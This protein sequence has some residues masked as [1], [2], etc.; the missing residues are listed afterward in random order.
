MQ[1]QFVKEYVL[2][3]SK[4]RSQKLGYTSDGVVNACDSDTVYFDPFFT[5]EESKADVYFKKK[6]DEDSISIYANEEWVDYIR[7]AGEFN[8]GNYNSSL[9]YFIAKD[10]FW[11]NFNK[12]PQD[13]VDNFYIVN[14]TFRYGY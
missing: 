2:L 12:Q 7:F 3:I 11:R 6:M 9:N 13:I 5:L 4:S 1:K 8:F 14:K 10:K